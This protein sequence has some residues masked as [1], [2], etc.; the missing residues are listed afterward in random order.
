MIN[1]LELTQRGS[2]AVPPPP[3][4]PRLL[5]SRGD[6]NT[7]VVFDPS[8]PTTSSDEAKV[9]DVAAP[10]LQPTVSTAI[11][12][13]LNSSRN[14]NDLLQP[15]VHSSKVRT[16]YLATEDERVSSTN[17]L[18]FNTGNRLYVYIFVLLLGFLL[19][20]VIVSFF[21]FLSLRHRLAQVTKQTPAGVP[22]T[23]SQLDAILAGNSSINSTDE[24][25]GT[26]K[27]VRRTVINIDRALQSNYDYFLVNETY[28]YAILHGLWSSSSLNSFVW[29][30]SHK[31]ASL[32]G[33]LFERGT[34]VP[35]LAIF[36]TLDQ[37]SIPPTT[38]FF[39]I[40]VSDVASDLRFVDVS[41]LLTF[42]QR[43]WLMR[44][45][46]VDALNEWANAL[47]YAVNFYEIEYTKENRENEH[48]SRVLVIAFRDAIHSDEHLLDPDQGFTANDIAHA[49]YNQ[50]HL[51]RN[52][53]FQLI[54]RPISTLIPLVMRDRDLRDDK[55]FALYMTNPDDFFALTSLSYR[56]VYSEIGRESAMN[57][58]LNLAA[59]LLHETGH[60]LGLS[61]YIGQ[62]VDDLRI[63]TGSADDA[64][65]MMASFYSEKLSTLTPLDKMAINILF[66]RLKLSVDA[67]R[68]HF[69]YL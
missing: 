40:F 29:Q 16:D 50:L 58:N 28:V 14:A 13:P 8:K 66:H 10:S 7:L 59:V 42:Q 18:Q 5:L 45:C 6:T 32:Q 62:F 23:A 15:V 26:T 37:D 24:T 47:E 12:A 55:N 60:V 44:A 52:F 20:L 65:S 61:H 30:D 21:T 69:P 22:L 2:V 34:T 68:K 63:E 53:N 64:T 49:G 19:S 46:I 3:K 4:P 33:R 56:H 9:E 48:F 54:P 38:E 11:S 31:L 51:N 41:S 27:R 1:R 17:S 36:W 35:S 43:V 25:R 39:A 67:V 57:V